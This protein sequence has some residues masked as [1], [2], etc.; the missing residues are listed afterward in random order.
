MIQVSIYLSGIRFEEFNQ[1]A[2]E[3]GRHLRQ[4]G[5]GQLLSVVAEII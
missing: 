2:E 1:L 4:V 3:V 5:D